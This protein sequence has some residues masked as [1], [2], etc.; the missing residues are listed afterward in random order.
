MPA[1]RIVV[2]DDDPKVREL[3]EWTLRPP[4]FEVLGFGDAR[5][6]LAKLPNARPHLIICDMMMPD[7]DGRMFLKLVKRSQPLKDVP[8]LFLTAVRV[9][10]EVQAAFDAGAAAFLVKPFPVARLVR[11]IRDV[12][13]GGGPPPEQAP[14]PPVRK[15]AV[16]E[17]PRAEA[18]TLPP[19][20]LEALQEP[21]DD[22]FTQMVAGRAAATEAPPPAPV[23]PDRPPASDAAPPPPA[24]TPAPV[25]VPAPIREAAPPLERPPVTIEGRFSAVELDGVRVQV[26]TEAESRPNFVITTVVSRDGQGIRRIETTWSHPLKRREDLDIVR[27]HIDLQHERVLD[28]IRRGPLQGPRRQTLWERGQNA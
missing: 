26:M 28:E 10:A 5:D 7:M 12:L 19:Q 4:E 17:K 15:P 14:P 16:R 22:D 24:A 6:A 27:R 13:E 9:G 3:I 2:V 8:F 18:E 20:R 21:T 23:E 11:T 25:R 1:K